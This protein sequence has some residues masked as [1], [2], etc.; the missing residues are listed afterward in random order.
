MSLYKKKIFLVLFNLKRLLFI[1]EM[2][3]FVVFMPQLVLLIL[4]FELF[5]VLFCLIHISFLLSMYHFVLFMPHLVLFIFFYFGL[6]LS[7]YSSSM[8]YFVLSES[9]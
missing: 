7:Y 4:Y 8:S 9:Q 6:S 3:H 5:V 1:V 2:S